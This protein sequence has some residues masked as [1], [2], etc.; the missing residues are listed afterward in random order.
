MSARGPALNSNKEIFFVSGNGGFQYCPGCVKHCAGSPASLIQEFTDFG[1][2]VMGIN[3]LNVWTPVNGVAQ[4]WP[5]DYF[6]PDAIPS[7]VGTGPGYFE[8][9][10]DEDWDM[11]VTGTLLFDD[12]WYDSSGQYDCPQNIC[13][14]VSMLLAANKR[15]DGYVL[16]QSYLGQ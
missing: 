6:V 8:I 3:M 11:G 14:N 9:L 16:F 15:G 4:F 1:E 5:I 13:P 7:G 2:A 12:N 10:S